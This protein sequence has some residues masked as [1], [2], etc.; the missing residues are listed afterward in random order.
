MN[1][2]EKI[3]ELHKLLESGNIT[4][5]EFDGLKITLLNEQD[6]PST[7]K[8]SVNPGTIRLLKRLS[9]F[10][11]T[12]TFMVIG[13]FT[14]FTENKS[15]DV[16]IEENIKRSAV[17]SVIAG[18]LALGMAASFGFA[19][20]ANFGPAGIVIGALL[21]GSSGGFVGLSLGEQVSDAILGDEGVT[22]GGR[23][24]RDNYEALNDGRK[25][26]DSLER[27]LLDFNE[28]SAVTKKELENEYWLGDFSIQK[29]IKKKDGIILELNNEDYAKLLIAT[30]EYLLVSYAVF[31]SEER[32]LVYNKLQKSH[33][34]IDDFAKG[35]INSSTILVERDYYDSLEPDDPNYQGHIF[36]EGEF[37]LKTQK[38]MK[39][40]NI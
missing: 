35:L 6:I 22:V 21:L 20:G 17:N 10:V 15:V 30:E 8:S 29:I 5:S 1:N 26:N 7:Q 2:Y 33:Y 34:I 9:L 16:E 28:I 31:G 11:I 3:T 25:A 32:T 13:G 4:Q 40:R 38:Y 27:I 12:I 24:D 18:S 23:T 39:L 37:N 36:E 19:K 14:E